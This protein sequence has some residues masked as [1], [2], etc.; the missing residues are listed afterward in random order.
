MLSYPLF[1]VFKSGHLCFVLFESRKNPDDDGYK[2]YTTVPKKQ[3][4]KKNACLT[5][6]MKTDAVGELKVVG[7]VFPKVEKKKSWALDA[8]RFWFER[9]EKKNVLIFIAM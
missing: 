2:R 1:T 6:E 3:T 9:E 7:L 8:Q 5:L 4:K